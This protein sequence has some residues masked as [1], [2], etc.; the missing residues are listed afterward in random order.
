[1]FIIRVI[2]LESWKVRKLESSR[3]NIQNS[4]L[5]VGGELMIRREKV[6]VNE[7]T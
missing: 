3:F 1:M 6:P 4:K 7:E 5:D 2:K